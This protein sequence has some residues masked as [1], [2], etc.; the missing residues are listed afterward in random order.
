MTIAVRYNK[1]ANRVVISLS[2][3]IEVI[4][5]PADVQGL[6]HAPSQLQ[7]TEIILGGAWIAHLE[8]LLWLMSQAERQKAPPRRAAKSSKSQ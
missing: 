3:K 5:N 8:A 1:K 2:G 7:E 6:E 4:F